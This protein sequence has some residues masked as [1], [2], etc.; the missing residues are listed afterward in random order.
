MQL[1]HMC[2]QLSQSQLLVHP[3][4][5]LTQLYMRQ[6][7]LV[8]SLTHML[9]SLQGFLGVLAIYLGAIVVV[10]ANVGRSK[11]ADTAY[12]IQVTQSTSIC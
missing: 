6:S 3:G 8:Q 9:L 12:C 4:T 10:M 2:P 7:N 1:W 11:M 5:L